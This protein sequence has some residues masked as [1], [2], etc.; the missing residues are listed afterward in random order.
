MYNKNK[1][2]IQDVIE[3]F[4]KIH[5]NLQFTLEHENNNKLNF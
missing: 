3:E 4:N 2:N 1:T 5:K